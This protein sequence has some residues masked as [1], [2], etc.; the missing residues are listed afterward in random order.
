VLP[1]GRHALYTLEIDGKP[2]SEARIMLLALD[3][4][5]SRLLIDGGSD[6]QYVSTGHIV[7]WRL[8]DLWAAPFDIGSL[9]LTGSPAVVLKNVMFGEANG[10]AHFAAADNGTIAYLSGPDTGADRGFVL[11][12]RTG[13]ARPLTTDRKAYENAMISPDGSRIALTVVA[14]ND[15]LWTLELDRG[16][17][18][19]ITFEGESAMPVW[20]PDGRRLIYARH[21]GG[22]LRRL[23]SVPADGGA[24]PELLHA[25]DRH[26]VPASSSAA[27]NLL[28]FTRIDD[29][30]G[31]DVWVMSL[32]GE[33]KARPWL[34]TRFQETQPQVSPNGRWIAYVSDESGRAQV[35]V[36]SYPDGA[37]KRQVSLE[38]GVEPR[39]RRD[40]RE[41]FYRRDEA[42]LSTQLTE[43]GAVLRFSVPAVL[44]KARTDYLIAS[45]AR[46]WDSWDVMPDGQHFVFIQDFSK[47]HSTVLLVQNWFAELK[48]KFKR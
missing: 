1:D 23:Y 28:A 38:G 15:S 18:T 26:E 34:A 42:V 5:Q 27:G 19:R 29:V 31:S 40:G 14:A 30:T 3:S 43:A 9:Q 16:L 44:F 20:S 35:Y 39:W 2:Y 45:P 47:P 32:E 33:R 41:L 8:G 37:N 6:A 25:S 7:Y 12:D 48:S 46:T 17:M 24:P 13:A 11:V 21:M 10:Y 22:E 36:R 4:G